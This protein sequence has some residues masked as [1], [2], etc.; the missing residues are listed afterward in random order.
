MNKEFWKR[1]QGF[2]S[3][4]EELKSLAEDL[5]EKQDSDALVEDDIEE[6]GDACCVLRELSQKLTARQLAGDIYQEPWP[7]GV[8][9]ISKS[10]FTRHRLKLGK[11]LKVVVKN[12]VSD[13]LETETIVVG[14]KA[15][16]HLD[17]FSLGYLGEGPR[18]FRWLLDQVGA[19]YIDRQIHGKQTED[20]REFIVP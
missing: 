6:L 9:E 11:V 10:Y 3:L 16:L 1:R 5:E 17:G 18:G 15:R 14:E 2:I 13:P 7:A 8:T 12:L 4:V 20:T 19:E